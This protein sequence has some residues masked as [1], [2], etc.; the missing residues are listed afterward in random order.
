[1]LTDEDLQFIAALST[2]TGFEKW[3]DKLKSLKTNEI[4]LEVL[5][6][7][8]SAIAEFADSEASLDECITDLLN[9]ADAGT[10][11]SDSIE[12][13]ARLNPSL[14]IAAYKDLVA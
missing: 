13:Y 7:V 2:A 14:F 9:S 3:H 1:M 6:S 5:K 10:W 12:E 4:S 11:G 8:L